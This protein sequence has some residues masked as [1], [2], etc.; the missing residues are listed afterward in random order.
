MGKRSGS[1]ANEGAYAKS[2]RRPVLERTRTGSST[3]ST[4]ATQFDDLDASREKIPSPKQKKAKA[5]AVAADDI[6]HEEGVPVEKIK[7]SADPDAALREAARLLAA[8]G[9]G[10]L[11]EA[12]VYEALKKSGY[13]AGGGQKSKFRK[14]RRRL[15]ITAHVASILERQSFI[16][17]LAKALMT[18]GAPSH[19]LESQLNATAQVL[20]VDAQFIHVPSVVIAS[21][22]DT[23]THTSETKFVKAAG[24][25]NLGSL[26]K[27][28]QIYRDVVHDEMSVE[29]GGVALSMLLKA[30]PIYNIA[31][32]MCIAA[33]CAGIIAPMG[34]GGSFVDAFVAGAFGA[35]LAFLQL[36]V[37]RRNAV[38]SNIFEISI[39]CLISFVSRGLSTT[40]LF[41]YEALSSA[42][43][44]LV[45]P[46]F[47]VLCGS[48]E[49]ASRNLIAGSVRMVYSIIY[50]LFLGFAI[51]VGSDVFY[52]FDPSAR[53]AHDAATGAAAST[54]S[55][56]GT[57]SAMNGSVMWT[58]TWT[59]ANATAAAVDNT[60]A[61]LQKGNVMCVRGADW[62]W[63]RSDVSAYWLFLLVP[64]FSFFLSLWNLQ[65]VRSREL[66]VMVAISI[67]GYIA[68]RLATTFIFDRSDIVSFIGATVIGL[69]GNLYSRLFNGTAFTA[70]A[71][72]VLFLVPSGIAAAG[73][74]AMDGAEG[75]TSGLSVAFKMLS[76]SI[77]ITTGLFFSS[78][79]IYTVG[80]KKGSG[81]L[82]FAF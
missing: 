4:E 78:F 32:R 40:N 21:F 23:D 1:I 50:T 18:F 28:H 79:L 11:S 37:A 81:G 58:G 75:Y 7:P 47:I 63:W 38:F 56:D 68:N 59:F 5:Q 14:N 66:P 30:K 20:Q 52:L 2:A 57:F 27:V 6:R 16:L 45:L 29:E 19:R 12:H 46:G 55:T 54:V 34:F 73:G 44:V 71:T 26:H 62:E 82:G 76:V 65:P 10:G 48:L 41:C 74:L 70:M 22:G 77:G 80:T 72:G 25:L 13:E 53:R 49:L 51:S 33:M 8:Q 69:L 17:K 24:G 61:S 15:D 3:A 60:Q 31:Q 43:V 36:Y 9:G 64:A 35:T 42:G 67:A 39:A